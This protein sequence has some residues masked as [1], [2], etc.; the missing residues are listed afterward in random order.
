MNIIILGPQGS[1][2][3]T[4]ARL[5]ANKLNLKIIEAGALVRKEAKNNPKIGDI[6]NVKGQLIPSNMMFGLIKKEAESNNR[7]I[8][9]LIL[10]GYPRSVGQYKLLN[11]WLKEN[12]ARIDKVV[13]LEISEEESIRRLSARRTCDKCGRLYNLITNPPSG[14]NCECGGK[15]VQRK[16]DKPQA[17]KKR[18]AEYRKK[19]E[20]ML[21]LFLEE[22]IL[23]K[24]DG[25]RPIEDIFQDIQKRLEIS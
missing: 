22:G 24:V 14:T 25:E 2:K 13:L 9:D 1:G 16:D 21:S 6:I 7:G 8:N 17:I 11:K 4:Q 23:V 19:T 18:L 3:G 10:D 12:N 5:L 20:P 15:L